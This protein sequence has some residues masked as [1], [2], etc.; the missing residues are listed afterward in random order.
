MLRG[1]LHHHINTDPIDG[2]F[3]RH[4]AGEL[5]DRAAAMGLNVLAITCHE[6]IPYDHDA[7][8]Y[9]A[10]RGVLLLRGMEARVDGH[11]VLLLNF[12]E[13]P[14]GVCSMAEVAASKTPEALV[15][16][17]H[18]FY[19]AGVAGA[20]SLVRHG[21]FFDAVEFSGLYT[22]LTRR[23]NRRAAEYARHV[24]LAVVGNSDTHFLWQMGRTYTLIDAAPEPA[25]VL[26]AIRGGRVQVVSQP[27]SWVHLVRF[28]LES[29]STAQLL[30]DSLRYM[31]RILRR[32]R[33]QSRA[34]LAG[35]VASVPEPPRRSHERR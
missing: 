26:A 9:A 6:S 2:A 15:I 19:P 4:S 29:H 34:V 22:P 7:T 23:F 30:G 3:V 27:L 31:V 5:I 20:E 28:I 24:G 10:E 25:A 8:R 18:P 16:A 14:P 1:D 35:T 32:T 17:P 13:F 12:R 33:Q 21:A 11:H